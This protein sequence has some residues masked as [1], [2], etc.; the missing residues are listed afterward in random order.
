LFGRRLH[1]AR[2][3]IGNVVE[4]EVQEDL[5][6]PSMKGIQ[7]LRA[8]AGKEFL[9]HLDPTS[10]RIELIRHAQGGIQGRVIE[11]NDQR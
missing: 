11:G 7:D 6:P 4:F 2:H 10:S 9:A 8:A 3:G 5:E 1:G